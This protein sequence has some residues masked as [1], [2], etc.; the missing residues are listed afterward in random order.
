M[1]RN[2]IGVEDAVLLDNKLWFI[3]SDYKCLVSM[4]IETKETKSYTIPTETSYTQNRSYASMALMGRKIY[5]IPFMDRVLWQ[6]EVDSEEF[7][8]VK[9]DNKFVENSSRLF[10]AMGTYKKFLFVMGAFTP[11]ILRIN[12]ENNQVDY[13]TDWTQDIEGLLFDMDEA[14]FRKLSV[15]IGEKLYVPFCGANAVLEIDCNNMKTVI[16]RMGVEKQGYSGICYDNE[17]IWLSPRKKGSIVKW[18]LRNNEVN[19]IQIMGLDKLGNAITYAGLFYFNE[20]ICLLPLAKRHTLHIKEKN[21]L[22]LV[23]AYSFVQEN[24]KHIL[25]YKKDNGVF[26]LIDK[27]SKTQS[28]IEVG[29]V[30]PDMKRLICDN[31]NFFEE[32]QEINIRDFIKFISFKSAE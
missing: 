9:L 21:V 23:G 7:I 29:K 1:K 10:M 22:E 17:S 27:E 14:Y 26:T 32:S 13:I 8:E 16:R 5:L 4:D 20:E 2:A 30:Y 11:A 18:D 25:F 24:E 3:L 31:G 28:E 6:F 15:V 19:M 12:T